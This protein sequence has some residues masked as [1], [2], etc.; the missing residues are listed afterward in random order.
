MSC[1]ARSAAA[2]DVV[3]LLGESRGELGGSEYLKVDAR[4]I[5][6]V[7]PA[8]DLD[9]RSRAAAPAR[10]SCAAAADSVG[11]RLRGRRARRDAGGVL[12]RY[13][14]IGVER[15][16]AGRRRLRPHGVTMRPTLFG[17]SA[18]RV[19]RLGHVRNTSSSCW[20]SC[21]GRRARSA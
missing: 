9:A 21:G 8:L 19:S 15:R 13:G 16:L 18:S 10:R 4:L 17:E 12:L 14:G 3:V 1:G 5:R 20:R 11:A 7:P 2:G 6:G